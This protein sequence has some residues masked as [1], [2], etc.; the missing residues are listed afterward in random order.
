MPIISSNAELRILCR[1]F[2][3]L[4]NNIFVHNFKYLGNLLFCRN[5]RFIIVNVILY[6]I[7]QNFL[8]WIKIQIKT[9]LNTLVKSRN[10]IIRD[11]SYNIL[12]HSA[13]LHNNWMCNPFVS[14]LALTNDLLPRFISIWWLLVHSP[15]LVSNPSKNRTQSINYRPISLFSTLSKIIEKVIFTLVN[16]ISFLPH[17]LDLK[18]DILH[19]IL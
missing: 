15:Q 8:F 9:F 2:P 16:T 5:I 3:N 12:V 11:K 19:C 7:K 17:S 6:M 18:S 13:T 1:L 14:S 4:I 10:L